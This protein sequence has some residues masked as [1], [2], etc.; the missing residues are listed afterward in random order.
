LPLAPGCTLTV[1]TDALCP[2]IQDGS[3]A[4]VMTQ[5]TDYLFNGEQ[6]GF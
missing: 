1:A 5:L 6:E 4:F 2:Q 3:V